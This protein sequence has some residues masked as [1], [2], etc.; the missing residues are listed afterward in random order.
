MKSVLL[1]LVLLMFVSAASAE[2]KKSSR[3]LEPLTQRSG[4]AARTGSGNTGM[5]I[6]T[7]VKETVQNT[8]TKVT[9]SGPKNGWGFVSAS[10]P[11]YTPQ[12]KNCGKLPGGTLFKYTD[13]KESSKNAMLVCSVKREEA[14]EGPVLLDCTDVS[15][16]EGSP[17]TLNPETVKKLGI[18]YTLNGRVADRKEELFDAKLAKNPHFEAARQAQMA[19][20]GSIAKA[21]A[22]EK[23]MNTLTGPSKAKADEALRALKYEQVRIKA[24]ADTAASAYKT[25]KASHPV[26]AS[27]LADDPQLTALEKE[28]QAAKAAVA[29]L[30]PPA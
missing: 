24:A 4:N 7:P 28:R 25:W 2:V 23:Q 21:A 22:M 11:Y 30:L 6:A 26:D 27:V 13:V 17:E 9:F 8:V 19:Y 3:N 18:Y 29:K 15:A 16:Y 14:W 20:Q 10:S 1:A 12:G 5:S